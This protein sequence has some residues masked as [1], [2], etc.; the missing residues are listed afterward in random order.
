MDK[1]RALLKT[2]AFMYILLALFSLLL[3]CL[4]DNYD[5][6]LYARLIV[7]EHFFK[8]GWITY[9]DFLSYTPTHLWYDHEWGASVV[10]Y[11]FLKLFGNFGLIL[12]QAIAIFFTTFFV[13]KT[14]Q[15]Q[16]HSYPTSLAFIAGF[17]I[18]FSHQNPSIV[19]CHMFSFSLFSM[20]LYFLEKT[21]LKNS[22]ILWLM[23]PIIIIWN[24]LHGGVVSG[25]GMIFIYMV[26]AIISRKPWRKYFGVLAISTPLLVINPYG[27]DYLN[28]LFSANTKNREYITEWWGVF[29]QRHVMYYY[30]LFCT[31]VFTILLT[32]VRFL[33]KKK[34]DITKTL[35]L[36]TTATLGFIHVKLLSLAIIVVAALFYNE[37]I[38]LVHKNGIKFLNKTA[39]VLIALAVCYIPFSKPNVARTHAGKYPIAEVEFIKQNKIEGNLITAFGLGSYTSYKLYPQNL[40]YMDGRYEEVY[41]DREF[42]NLISYEK[43]EPIIWETVITNYPTQILMPEKV[44][45]IYEFLR[46]NPDWEEVYTGPVCGVFLPRKR[47]KHNQTFLLPP[48]NLEYYQEREFENFGKFG[49]SQE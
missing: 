17:M 23:P 1:I 44:M 49:K 48:Q 40:I 33:N 38:R 47:D 22:N 29:V 8:T 21:R 25:M 26:A 42:D 36:L 35:A 16:K 46:K 34:I 31:L 20:L 10:F 37:I 27:A 13:I 41:Y 18:L 2:R 9:Q 39:Y 3:A 12:V 32:L 30:P 4:S 14:Q 45:P 19:R 24:N 43:A 15:L 5:Y 28:F 6:D 7:G 11:A